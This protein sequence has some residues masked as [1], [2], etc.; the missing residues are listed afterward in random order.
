ML[1]GYDFDNDGAIDMVENK[2]LVQD[3]VREDKYVNVKN[4]RF[5]GGKVFDMSVRIDDSLM[6]LTDL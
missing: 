6:L 2:V 3:L 1:F 5:D 4:V